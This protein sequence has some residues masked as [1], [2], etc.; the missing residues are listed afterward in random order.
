VD[1]TSSYQLGVERA[2]IVGKAPT[3]IGK[4]ILRA[5]GLPV[6]PPSGVQ[7]IRLAWGEV[8]EA[9]DRWIV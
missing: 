9:S 7:R 6:V 4:M 3:E 8:F 2:T 5:V 1:G